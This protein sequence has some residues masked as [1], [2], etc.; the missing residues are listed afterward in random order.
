MWPCD[1]RDCWHVRAHL[2]VAAGTEY[3]GATQ[4]VAYVALKSWSLR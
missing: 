3:P 2:G 4:E 1:S